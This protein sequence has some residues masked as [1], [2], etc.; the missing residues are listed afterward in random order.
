MN[1][2]YILAKCRKPVAQPLK[3]TPLAPLVACVSAVETVSGEET[4]TQTTDNQWKDRQEINV[5]QIERIRYLQPAP[6]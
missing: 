5:N 1:K 2:K 3:P 6:R 4:P